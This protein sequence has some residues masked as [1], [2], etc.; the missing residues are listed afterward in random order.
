MKALR[1]FCRSAFVFSQN[2]YD[3]AARNGQTRSKELIDSDFL[4]MPTVSV[5][6]CIAQ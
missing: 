5:A 2:R 6:V 1:Y 3:T 4:Y